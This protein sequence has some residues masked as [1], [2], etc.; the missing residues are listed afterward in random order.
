MGDGLG[1]GFSV[2]SIPKADLVSLSLVIRITLV[3]RENSSPLPIRLRTM[4]HTLL[5]TL[6]ELS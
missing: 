2:E 6:A 3:D 1:T 4:S 5:C